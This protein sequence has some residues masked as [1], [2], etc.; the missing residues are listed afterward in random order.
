MKIAV[1]SYFCLNLRPSLHR[2]RSLVLESRLS[3]MARRGVNLRK[4]APRNHRYV[5]T[6]QLDPRLCSSQ[7]SHS[8]CSFHICGTKTLFFTLGASTQSK[9]S[10]GAA[11]KPFFFTERVHLRMWLQLLELSRQMLSKARK[12]ECFSPK[13]FLRILFRICYFLAITVW[14]LQ[15]WSLPAL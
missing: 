8:S 5:H 14:P 6:K 11:T 9:I 10:T 1:M 2:E 15:S 4:L 7:V 12:W 3:H 13:E